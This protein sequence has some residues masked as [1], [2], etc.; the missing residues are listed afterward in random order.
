MS[1]SEI[2]LIV[3]VT[4]ILKDDGWFFVH[5]GSDIITHAVNE[6]QEETVKFATP[7]ELKEWIYLKAEDF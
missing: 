5:D 7:T 3:R 1:G 2:N 4:Q 6:E